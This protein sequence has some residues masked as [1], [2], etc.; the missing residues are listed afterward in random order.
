MTGIIAVKGTVGLILLG[1]LVACSHQAK[2]VDC[3][4]HL[5]AINP[6]TPVVKP[7]AS[8]KTTSP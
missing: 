2:K 8:G 7:A 1:A 4:K 5:V 6:P 3:D